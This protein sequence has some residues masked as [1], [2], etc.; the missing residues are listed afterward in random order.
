MMVAWFTG[1]VTTYDTWFSNM[2]VQD[3]N[4]QGIHII[5]HLALTN[6]GSSRKW[7]FLL[8]PLAP[9]GFEC[10]LKMAILGTALNY[11]NVLLICVVHILCTEHDTHVPSIYAY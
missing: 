8:N 9:W 1:R 11:T 6:S 2:F 3:M 10:R 7:E 5:S 4:V